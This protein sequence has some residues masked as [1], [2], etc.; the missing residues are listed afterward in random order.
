MSNHLSRRWFGTDGIRGVYGTDPM[1]PG[2]ARAA[3]RAAA[4]YFGNAHPKPLFIIGRDTRLS[5]PALEQALIEGITAG[6]GSVRATGVLPTAAVAIAVGAFRAQAGIMISASHN[7][8]AD[9]GIKFFDANGSKLSDEAECAIESLIAP[10]EDA[11]EKNG[12][13]SFDFDPEAFDAYRGVLLAGLDG[14][15]APLQGLSILVDAANGAAWQTTP[16]ILESLGARVTLLHARPDG[17]NIN[18]RCGSQHPESLA[19]EL[20]KRNDGSIGLAHDGDADRLVLIDEGGEPLDGDELLAIAALYLQK[21]GELRNNL[22][23]ATVMSNLG[24]DAALQSHGIRVLRTA[25]GDRYVLEGMR[26]AGAVLGG[27]QSG[28]M[29]FLGKL[30]TGDGLLSALQILLALR[31]EGKTL[32]EARRIMTKFPQL[33]INEKVGKKVPLEQLP[34]VQEA[35]RRVEAGFQGRGRVLLRYSGTE[36]KIRLL[37]EGPDGKE[38]SALAAQILGPIR[39]ELG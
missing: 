1:T 25:V 18:E 30:G 33:L 39:H 6:G 38:L 10:A 15:S 2:F 3:G 31:H 32:R 29:L 19:A 7:P 9:N 35:V 21:R 8:A 24:L 5:G 37:L 27:E 13:I 12:T 36:N 28:H 14:A 20:R 34:S 16:K 4:L 11:A 17:R 23:A 26:E 22:V